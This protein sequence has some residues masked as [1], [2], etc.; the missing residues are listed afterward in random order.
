MEKANK[1]TQVYAVRGLALS[2]IVGN[3]FH[4]G[5]LSHGEWE[6]QPDTQ[7]MN[8]SQDQTEYCE[9]VINELF[10]LTDSTDEN[11]EEEILVPMS[12]LEWYSGM[13]KNKIQRAY[14]RFKREKDT[15]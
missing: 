5:A 9:G 3:A 12:F 11:E 2:T 10:N 7:W 8:V 6:G 15:E 1:L 4:A 13:D 14:E